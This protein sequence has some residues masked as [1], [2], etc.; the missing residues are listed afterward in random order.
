MLK[1]E[2]LAVPLEIIANRMDRILFPCVRKVL[3]HVYFKFGVP[4]E[5]G[6]KT[7][8]HTLAEFK[9]FVNSVHSFSLNVSILKASRNTISKGR[10]N[11]IDPHVYSHT[12]SEIAIWLRG[13]QPNN[14]PTVSATCVP[15]TLKD[16]E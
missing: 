14:A 8:Y 5:K 11:L 16:W 7:Q 2:A 1:K 4:W 15:G 10:C 12:I 9:V 3:N 13:L 6:T